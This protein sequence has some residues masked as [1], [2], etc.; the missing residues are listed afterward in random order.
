[1]AEP[2][3]NFVPIK[4]IKNG[5]VILKDGSLR[6]VLMTSSHN[7]ALKSEEEQRAI[8][9]QF[10]SFLNSLDFSLQ[11][12]TQSRELDI[13]PYIAL[14]EERR[15]DQSSDLMK[16]QVTE[17]I[18]FVKKFTESVNIMKKTF[19]IVVPYQRATLNTQGGFFTKFLPAKKKVDVKNEQERFEEA[20]TQ[21]EQRAGVVEQGL[22]S[23]GLRVAPLHTEELVELYYRI[24]NPGELEKPIPM[25]RERG[26]EQ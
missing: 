15:K 17:Y 10:Q 26:K 2:A 1:M 7:L 20:R 5:V 16:I 9:Q 13:R 11:I 21:L 19:F 18:N 25:E 6:M 22:A 23:T 12:F 3:Q 14:L 24:F 8:L 4:E